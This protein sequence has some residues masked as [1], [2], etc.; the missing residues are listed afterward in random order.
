MALSGRS[1]RWN[2]ATGCG[3][4]SLLDLACIVAWVV[5]VIIIYPSIVAEAAPDALESSAVFNKLL[6]AA[7]IASLFG[8][9]WATTIWRLTSDTATAGRTLHISQLIACCLFIIHGAILAWSGVWSIAILLFLL[10][11]GDAVWMRRA[12]DRITVLVELLRLVQSLVSSRL[13]E[14]VVLSVALTLVQFVF[15]VLWVAAV[16]RVLQ[17]PTL[18][19]VATVMLIMLMSYRWTTGAIKHLLVSYSASIP[20]WPRA[21]PTDSSWRTGA[22]SFRN[23]VRLCVLAAF[24]PPL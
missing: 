23:I 7:F 2:V 4:R 11:W 12:R 16:A 18:G 21:A 5:H 6:A 9:G 14:L 15:T 22:G 17:L 13:R 1:Q 24:Q 20:R 8:L 3:R 10:A 19:G